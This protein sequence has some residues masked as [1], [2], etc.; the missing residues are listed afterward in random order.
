MV[1]VVGLVSWPEET[2]IDDRDGKREW[3]RVEL[4]SG[5][6]DVDTLRD[7]FTPIN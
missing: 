4:G 3:G 6:F 5:R 7:S 1:V 2:D